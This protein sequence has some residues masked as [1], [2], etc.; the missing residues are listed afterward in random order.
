MSWF[1]DICNA[2]SK[3]FAEVFEYEFGHCFP[4]APDTEG[5]KWSWDNQEEIGEWAWEHR[6]EIGN[7]L[8]LAKD[9]LENVPEDF[10]NT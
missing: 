8:N 6:E 3:C 9:I 5:N 7:S 4:A 10:T 2:I 1:D